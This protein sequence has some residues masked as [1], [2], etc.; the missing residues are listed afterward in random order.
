MEEGEEEL[1]QFLDYE[2]ESLDL[3]SI[4]FKCKNWPRI[5]TENRVYDIISIV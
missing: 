1:K 3:E 4:T 2:G 5:Y